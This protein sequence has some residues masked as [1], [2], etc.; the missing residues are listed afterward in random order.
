MPALQR[1]TEDLC[2]L[3]SRSYAVN[4]AV[5]LVGD[6]FGLV[7]RQ[8]QAVLRAACSDAALCERTRRAVGREAL[9]GR[10]VEIDTFNLLITIEAALSQ[11]VVLGCRDGTYRDMASIHGSYRKVEQTM[12]AITLIGRRLKQLRVPS[13]IWRLD[14]PVSNSGRL[15]ALLLEHAAVHQFAWD[16]RLD[17]NPD[18]VLGSEQPLVVSADA[19][20]LDRVEHWAN[21]ARWV[22]TEDVPQAWI[23]PLVAGQDSALAT[24]PLPP[25][26][27]DR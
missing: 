6:R 12:A 24:V 7:D 14:R 8:R 21:L 13:A 5:K 16:V 17:D 2:W 27:E 10:P 22:V 3:F 18:R 19:A 25:G 9:P 26:N 23:V 1:A 20:V 15:R 11:G 4:S